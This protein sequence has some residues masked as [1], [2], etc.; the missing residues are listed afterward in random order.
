MKKHL[1]LIMLPL[2]LVAFALVYAAGSKED[3]EYGAS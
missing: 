1:V 2:V 3:A